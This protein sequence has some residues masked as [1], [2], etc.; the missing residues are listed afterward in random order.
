MCEMKRVNNL[1]D[2]ETFRAEKCGIHVVDEQMALPTV[3]AVADYG[4]YVMVKDVKSMVTTWRGR[5]IQ[6]QQ[7]AQQPDELAG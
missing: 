1:K 7:A 4:I 6:Q 3:A 2:V 5:R